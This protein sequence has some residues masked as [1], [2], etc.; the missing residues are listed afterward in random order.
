MNSTLLQDGLTVEMYS[1]AVFRNIQR[2]LPNRALFS[3]ILV[4][5]AT[6]TVIKMPA[7][8]I[9]IGEIGKEYKFHAGNIRRIIEEKDHATNSLHS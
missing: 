7:G 8:A 1:G 3:G 6:S 9:G 4:Q 2:L 5:N